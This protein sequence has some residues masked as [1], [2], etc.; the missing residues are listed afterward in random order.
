MIVWLCY[1]IKIN[2][3]C[4][5]VLN[6]T[7]S[8]KYGEDR[9]LTLSTY[10]QISSTMCNLNYLFTIQKIIHNGNDFFLSR[11]HLEK[12]KTQFRNFNNLPKHSALVLTNRLVQHDSCP[13]PWSELGLADIGYG[14]G[15]GTSHPHPLANDEAVRILS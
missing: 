1:L 4:V 5:H 3:F 8:I 12:K 15:F 6:T 11:L 13:I 14:T 2:W 7:Y 9:L 10:M